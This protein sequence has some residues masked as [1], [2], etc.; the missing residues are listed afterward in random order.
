MSIYNNEEQ[1]KK[2]K[3]IILWQ[4]GK[5]KSYSFKY[6][7]PIKTSPLKT[8][9]SQFK[10]EIIMYIKSNK[11]NDSSINEIIHYNRLKELESSKIKLYHLYTIKESDLEEYDIPYLN[12]NDVLFFLL[13]TLLSKIVTIFI[14]MNS[15]GG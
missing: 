5:N 14:N 3:E 12:T 13:I 10:E 11:N 6:K 2:Y 8:S 9:L 1:N 7:I 4:N 15:L